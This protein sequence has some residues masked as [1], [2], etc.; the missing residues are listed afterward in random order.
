[1]DKTVGLPTRDYNAALEVG[2]ALE[3]LTRRLFHSDTGRSVQPSAH[4]FIP[5]EWPW[6][7][8]N[9]D[10][11]M[12]GVAGKSGDGVFEG[13]TT[14]PYARGQWESEGAPLYYLV[15]T[16]HYMACT[17]LDWASIAVLVL[18]TKNPLMWQDLECD[19]EFRDILI[20]A[21]RVFWHDHVLA[22]RAPD[23]DAHPATT[24]VLQRLH[25]DDSGVTVPLPYEAIEWANKRT[26]AMAHKREVETEID[27]YTNRIKQ[28]IGD[29]TI[30]E[31]PDG[32]GFSW[33]TEERAAYEVRASKRRAFR[34]HKTKKAMD[35][36]KARAELRLKEL[37]KGTL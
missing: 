24:E 7:R 5:D 4:T 22:N 3:P 33:K 17:G 37:G 36:A 2:H 20:E 28:A 31:L 16:H 6:M 11:L 13:K 25:P 1:M 9:I 32:T 12:A 26:D 21:E 15:Q 10:G 27:L 18:G 34:Q 19:T 35:K 29:A 8:G 30:G 14:N 23:V